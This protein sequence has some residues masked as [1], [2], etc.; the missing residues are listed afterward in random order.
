VG[1]DHCD[2]VQ[3]HEDEGRLPAEGE[4]KP[5]LPVAMKGNHVLHP[6]D[7]SET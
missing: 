4:V 7:R 5:N 3:T 1:C 6:G 2:L